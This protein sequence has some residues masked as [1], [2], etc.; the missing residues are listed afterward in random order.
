MRDLDIIIRYHEESFTLASCISLLSSQ[1]FLPKSVILI[2]CGN[3][4]NFNSKQLS[5]LNVKYEGKEFNYSSAL[6]QGLNFIAKN[7]NF[8]IMSPHFLICDNTLLERM[9]KR[10]DAEDDVA[11]ITLHEGT[12]DNT[13]SIT[14][15]DFVGFNG[16]WNT[17]TIYKSRMLKDKLFRESIPAAEDLVLTKEIFETGVYKKIL[18]ISS[19]QVHNINPSKFHPRKKANDYFVVYKYVRDGEFHWGEFKSF[20]KDI[21]RLKQNSIAFMFFLMKNIYMFKKSSGST[22]RSKYK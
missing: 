6:N 14:E 11:A 21:L 7:R 19:P 20:I 8:L 17:C 16:L 15:A 2:N 4:P 10:L 1:T 18:R 9:S 13:V 12:V 22:I 5:I 3:G